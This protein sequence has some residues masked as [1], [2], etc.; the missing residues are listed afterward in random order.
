MSRPWRLLGPGLRDRVPARVRRSL[1]R[2]VVAALNLVRRYEASGLAS[3]ML[4]PSRTT[5]RTFARFLAGV[6]DVHVA[7]VA[8]APPPLRSP[9]SHDLPPHRPIDNTY[10]V[11]DAAS[12]GLSLRNNHVIGPHRRVLSESKAGF[13]A[14]RIA[15]TRLEPARHRP[16]TIAYLSNIWVDNYYHWMCFTLPNLRLLAE[17]LGVRPDLV[18]VGRPLKGWHLETLAAFGIEAS[19]VLTEG[20]TGD[21]IV[22][23]FPDRAGA[24][25]GPS[26]DFV[27]RTFR[28]EPASGAPRRRLFIGRGRTRHRRVLNEEACAAM[29]GE[30]YGFEAVTMDGMTVAEQ[31]ATFASAAVIIAP[32]GAAL[33]NLMFVS[34]AARVVE[35]VP[36]EPEA[37]EFSYFAE[38]C[39]H[40]GCEYLR[41]RGLPLG[42]DVDRPTLQDIRVDLEA[43][44]AVAAASVATS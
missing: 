16:G 28:P 13:D 23:V 22:A 17:A 5:L 7:R 43:L 6:A 34:A 19:Q 18:Y 30:R 27:R 41:L 3:G 36:H 10:I 42:R 39:A 1:A 8:A 2:P 4:T 12:P 15:L 35:L 26:L 44:D 14:L 31:A 11:V 9:G 25:D 33:T 38:L 32:H 37:V 20:T 40:V 29:L 24:L 21:R